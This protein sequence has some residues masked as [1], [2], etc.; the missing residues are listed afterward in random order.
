MFRLVKLGC[1]FCA[2][3]LS[4]ASGGGC[5]RDPNVRKQKFFEQ[6]NRDFE[7]GKY[8]EALIFY[9][10]ALQI[11]PCFA[12]AHYKMARCHVK[13]GSWAPAYQKVQRAIDLQPE[14]WPAQLDLGQHADAQMLLANSDTVLGNLKAAIGKPISYGD[15]SAIYPG[16]VRTQSLRRWLVPPLG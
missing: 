7:Q 10:R 9:G 12:E 14:N 1:F 15:G 2:L 13:Q 16:A 6:G 11:D 8:S 3:V 4:T 5:F